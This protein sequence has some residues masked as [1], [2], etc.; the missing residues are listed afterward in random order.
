MA[1]RSVLLGSAA[2]LGVA[3]LGLPG[4]ALA[5]DG[6]RRL[7]NPFALGVAS[8]DPAPDGFVIWTRLAPDPT[9]RR[10]HGRHAL[11]GPRG[12]LGGRRGRPLARIT[13]RDTAPARPDGG[14][15]V[16]VELGGL[17]PGREYFYRFSVDGHLSPSG[18]TR[19]Q[20]GRARWGVDDGFASCSQYEHGWFTA[21]RR[22]AEEEPWCPTANRVSTA[23]DSRSRHVVIRP[24]NGKRPAAR[25]QPPSR[26]AGPRRGCRPLSGCGG[27]CRR[28]PAS[29][30]RACPR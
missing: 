1:R 28:T 8:G 15:A 25:A 4:A 13:R 26:D 17:R 2:G 16:H 23:S 29:L 19:T 3:T 22:L 12:G 14:H 5:Q 10:R 21:Y 20:P 11:A 18:R 7:R 24:R 9:R 6:S 30:G 27:G